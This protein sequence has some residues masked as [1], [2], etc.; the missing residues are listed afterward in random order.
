MS[1]QH[2]PE[3]PTGPTPEP[4]R[5]PAAEP[6]G[7]PT[8]T[9][10]GSWLRRHRGGLW[11]TLAGVVTVITFVTGADN[12]PDLFRR[13]RP[14]DSR[15]V[16]PPTGE[17]QNPSDGSVNPSDGRL[18]PASR[19]PGVP[20]AVPIEA[21]DK[22]GASR[23]VLL[24]VVG[25]TQDEAGVHVSVTL[26]A[27]DAADG[28]LYYLYEATNPES[29]EIDHFQLIDATGDTYEQTGQR[30]IPSSERA[31]FQ[32]ACAPFTRAA[33]APFALEFRGARLTGD[34]TLAHLP[35]P[36]RFTYR[37]CDGTT[38]IL[39]LFRVPVPAPAG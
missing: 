8:P 37:E 38:V 17:T 4:T 32:L 35:D 19:E 28:T 1:D 24:T 11:T 2:T 26:G 10:R 18:D 7:D 25:A 3:P 12:L 14:D 30:G 21:R 31:R 39:P 33:A 20:E 23:Q 16:A 34:A 36:R 9:P 15:E 27:A 5:E 6:A 22:R 13:D 29:S